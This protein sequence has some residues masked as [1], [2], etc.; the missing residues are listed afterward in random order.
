MPGNG[1]IGIIIGDNRFT[2]QES[3][4]ISFRSCLREQGKGQQILSRFAVMNGRISP[5]P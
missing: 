3:C 1:E 5:G 2:C 4:E